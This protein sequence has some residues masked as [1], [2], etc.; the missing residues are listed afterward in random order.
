M[1]K[2]LVLVVLIAAIAASFLWHSRD[3][4]VVA[5]SLHLS[6]SDPCQL[7][8]IA[9]QR[10]LSCAYDTLFRPGNLPGELKPGLA[11]A[12]SVSEDGLNWELQLRQ[13][14]YFHN[15]E[16][17][18]GETAARALT[19]LFEKDSFGRLQPS[20]AFPAAHAFL[21]GTGAI[22]SIEGKDSVLCISLNRP[23]ADLGEILA[24]PGLSLALEDGGQ[25]YGTGPYRLAECR[26]GRAVFERFSEN[27][28]T[29]G[30]K[31]IVFID[32]P[33]SSVRRNELASGKV[34]AALELS[35]RDADLLRG[36][37]SVYR[38]GG[39]A[40]L[41]LAVNCSRRPFSNIRSRIALQIA[42]P[43]DELV[44]QWFTE[45]MSA[46]YLLP[47][48]EQKLYDKTKA[49]RLWDRAGADGKD[50]KLLYCRNAASCGDM[51]YVAKH[52]A[53]ELCQS[54]L[55][56]EPAGLD[57]DDFWRCLGL[58]EYE[59]AVVFEERPRSVPDVMYRLPLVRQKCVNI[60][61][62]SEDRLVRVL[63]MART[64]TDRG[65]RRGYYHKASELLAQDAVYAPLAEAVQYGASRK[66]AGY[67][68]TNRLGMFEFSD[69]G[70]NFEKAD[71]KYNQNSIPEVFYEILEE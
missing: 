53:A 56:V 36:K 61:H 38:E 70:E 62:Y 66:D 5:G 60:A 20:Q 34:D 29:L 31:R 14:I 67:W 43:K 45:A 21:R 19:R 65:M 10:I 58:G 41:F 64:V 26:A 23:I 24:Q 30:Y 27:S 3:F 63:D 71:D 48:G 49:S 55:N 54:G 37:F 7:P 6:S 25:F 13:D 1:K 52:L 28:G 17:L 32:V 51:A 9:Q 50:M 35:D 44:S 68:Q 59:M 42:L 15:G 8:D 57:Y 22:L 33:D 69:L 4:A 18:T 11:K 39:L 2:Y 12:Y 47:G 46:D 40:S 16:K